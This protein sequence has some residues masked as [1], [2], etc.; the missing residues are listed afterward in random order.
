MSDERLLHLTSSLC[1]TCKEA[2]PARVVARAAP[3][4]ATP[5]SDGPGSDGPGSDRTVWLRKSCPTHGPQEVCLCT[6]VAWYEETRAWRHLRRPQREVS[7]AVDLGCPYDCGP[8]EQH[9][10]DLAMPVVTITSACNLDCP[11]CYV[12]NK[13]DNAFHMALDDF[14]AVVRHIRA[15]KD[16]DVDLINLTGGEPMLHPRF[17][18]FLAIAKEEGVRRVTICSNGLKLRDEALVAKL[19]GLGARVALSFDTFEAEVDVAMQGVPLLAPKLR[20]LE[21]LERHGVDVTLIPVVTRGYNDHEIGRILEL[22]MARSNVRHVEVHLMTYTGQG[23]ATFD[24]AGRITLYETLQR[25]EAQTGWLRIDDFVPSPRAHPLCYQVAYL[26]VDP[27][28]G[29]ESG[30]PIPF[31]RLLDRAT[32]YAA[33]GDSLY[34]E[35]TQRLESALRDAIDRLWVEDGN[36]RV[37]GLLRRL[38]RDAFALDGDPNAN[39]RAAE[40]WIKAVYVHAHMDEESFDTERLAACC[41]AN[42]YPDGSTIPVCAY[43][44]LY[45]EKETNFMTAPRVWGARSG[46]RFDLASIGEPPK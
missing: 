2:L 11:I 17:L 39:L 5:G 36:E 29:P 33:L 28:G 22:G 10:V 45:R 30:P 16:G 6:S 14:R 15:K 3:G 23:G 24:R 26:L 9:Q 1:G 12:H 40:R 7:R 18:E 37:L 20:A 41:D 19:A 13:N 27:D 44:V 32:L 8:C 21:L 38:M 34:L 35:P 46:G 4:S 25:I 43:N 42:C 31:T